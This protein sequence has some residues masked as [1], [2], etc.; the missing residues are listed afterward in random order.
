M[1]PEKIGKYRVTCRCGDYARRTEKV[2]DCVPLT[3]A[4]VRE[5]TWLPATCAYRRVAERRDLAWWHPLVS[6]RADTVHEAGISVRGRVV[7]E[8]DVA[9]EDYEQFVASWPEED[10]AAGNQN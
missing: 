9:V 3:P 2:P 6:G 5:I 4:A 10:P 1:D 7:S 8:D